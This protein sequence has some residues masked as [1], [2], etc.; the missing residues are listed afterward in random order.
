MKLEGLIKTDCNILQFDTLP[1]TNDTAKDLGLEGAKE[2]TIVIAGAQTAG[3]GRMGRQFFS[4]DNSGIYMSIL[5]RP[6]FSAEDSRLLTPAAAV[7][8]AEAIDSVCKTD[9]KIKWVNDIYLSD[10]KVCGILT[11][12]TFEKGS[13]FSVVGIGINVFKPTGGFPD[14]I[15]DIAD[16][17]LESGTKEI[18][19]RLI[20]E[21]IDRFNY[22]YNLLPDTAFLRLY[23]EKSNLIGKEITY[24]KNGEEI[25]A[26]VLDIDDNAALIVDLGDKT[27]SLFTGEVSVKIK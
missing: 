21:V 22:Y 20:A 19:S 17:I 1:S 26:T 7:A 16:F 8:V 12:N 24:I 10:K 4:P 25:T 23:R 3:R 18:R 13:F 15:R 27:D 9:C 6:R 14:E 11:E 5:L 2:N